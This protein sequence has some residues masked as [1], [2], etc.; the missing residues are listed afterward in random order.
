ME[1]PGG[2]RCFVVQVLR[3]RYGDLK[4]R[5]VM[6]GSKQKVKD[7]ISLWWADLLYIES[8]LSEEIFSR[9]Y[10]FDVGN[11]YVTPFW[12]SAWTNHDIFKE[13][14]PLI[15]S[16]SLLQDVSATAM[17]GWGGNDW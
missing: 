5:M 15:F 10:H 4:C 14:F 17:G 13:G 9:G 11:G 16:K 7:F 1:N 6:D 8:N 2:N 3:A 12:H